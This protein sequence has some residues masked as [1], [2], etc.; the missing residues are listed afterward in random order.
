MS[1]VRIVGGG[2]TG[3][4]AAL[5]A[6]RLGCRDIELYERFDGLGGVA[7]PEVRGGLELRDGCI[8]FGPPGDPIRGLL[9]AHGLAFSDFDNRF[10]SVSPGRWGEPLFVEDFGGPALP[11]GE[12]GLTPPR[13]GSLAHRLDA[14][15][16]EIRAPLMRYCL[17]H[18]GEVAHELD[19]SSAIPL[20]INRVFPSEADLS[21]LAQ[22]KRKS[23]LAD[24]LYAIPRSLWRRTANL[25]AAL[26]RDGFP[27]FFRDCRRVLE[28]LGV[29]VRERTLVSPRQ[30]LAEHAAGEVLV[31]AGN[32][33]PLFKA[34][35]VPTPKL[36]PK[37]YWAYTH[38]VRWTGAA[39]FYVQNFTAQ[40]VCFRIYIYESRGQTL[41]TAE[42]VAECGE[43][44]LRGEVASLLAGF[45]GELSMGELLGVSIK[46][47]W[48]FHT[49][50]AMQ[51]LSQLRAALAGRMGP[52]FVPG[53]WEPYAKTEKFAQVNAALAAALDV[54]AGTAAA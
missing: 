3:V 28:A 16:V 10:G 51:R 19:A 42:C 39:P 27:A 24:D 29:T 50:E 47:R 15:P 7:L 40:G 38:K 36:L 23:P 44:E 52:A 37:S 34:A 53:A 6:H 18:L 26:P 5:E 1:K 2:L 25:V 8:Y 14:Y 21:V 11:T 4:L 48:I 32:P 33:T 49:L 46:P 13:G 41:L 54:E 45:P 30:A 31:W 17:W 9:E 20:A 22:A 12:I 43:P 35:G